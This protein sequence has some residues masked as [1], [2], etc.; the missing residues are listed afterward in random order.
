MSDANNAVIFTEV[1]GPKNQG[2]ATFIHPSAAQAFLIDPVS[3]ADPALAR[4]LC[5]EWLRDNAG[6]RLLQPNNVIE[7]LHGL[8]QA[9]G[10]QAVLAIIT[11]HR[12]RFR[13]DCV[14]NA[15]LYTLRENLRPELKWGRVDSQ[16]TQVLGQA[17][18]PQPE[19]G[20]LDLGETEQLLLCSDGLDHEQVVQSDMAPHHL[21]AGQLRMMLKDL[22]RESDWSA[23]LFPVEARQDYVNHQWPYNPFRGPQEERIHERRGLSR[24]AEALFADPA[25]NGFLI[26]PCPAMVRANSSRLFDGLL[27]SP[28]GAFPLE[29]KDYHGEVELRL[30][31]NPGRSMV[32][33][34][35]G[36][37]TRDTSP[38]D[39]LRDGLRRFSEL[40]PL[41][42][43]QADARRAGIVV[44]THPDVQVSCVDLDN[45]R[46]SL[47][48]QDGEVLVT[49]PGDLTSIV[50]RYAKKY[51][52]K[53]MRPVMTPEQ[54]EAIAGELLDDRPRPGAVDPGGG[55]AIDYDQPLEH[56]S[57]GY[58]RVY[59]A[60]LDGDA[61]WAK[62]FSL[63]SLSGVDRNHELQRIGREARVLH[64]LSRRR[65]PGVPYFYEARATDDALYVFV[66]PGQPQTLE[67]WIAQ[68]PTRE[69]RWQVLH[70]LADILQAIARLQPPVI[71][72]AINP[73]NVRVFEDNRAQLINFELCQSDTLATLLVDA[74]RSFQQEYQAPEVN[75]T[76]KQLT[77]AADV[78]SFLLC[79][80]YTLTGEPLQTQKL[81]SSMRRES[82]AF[83]LVAAMGLPESAADLWRRGLHRS[84]A[85][86]PEIEEI[87]TVMQEW[88]RHG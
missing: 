80:Y 48:Y 18:Q 28:L 86:R 64:K 44:F 29:L 61:V 58:Y 77:P 3:G 38:I 82:Y 31:R 32:M 1:T 53:K 71:H 68:E 60:D 51:C 24:I 7:E 19:Y 65:I 5:L 41:K 34:D 55:Y 21:A 11:Q 25:F 63:S 66:E 52:G 87:L 72:R 49:R 20:Q 27:L 33:Y 42:S 39:K 57:T 22:A 6:E 40:G 23:I 76:G 2:D 85:Q 50:R 69:Q 45:N 8:L 54:I 75:E 13:I 88:Q 83:K 62:T 12:G 26:L 56:E 17:S 43:V 78:F 36:K 37:E 67:N 84:P 30:G 73:R 35:Q 74:R 4:S 46:H 79:V 70:S 59:P 10:T 14:G 81:A 9:H 15:R 47:P 16:P